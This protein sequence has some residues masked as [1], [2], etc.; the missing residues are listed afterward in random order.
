M[1]VL[2]KNQAMKLMLR[3]ASEPCL[4]WSKRFVQRLRARI[5]FSKKATTDNTPICEF[6]ILPTC[7]EKSCLQPEYLSYPRMLS[8]SWNV[9]SPQSQT[10][11]TRRRLLKPD[12]HLPMALARPLSFT[13]S[14][15]PATSMLNVWRSRRQ[16]P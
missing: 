10:V 14:D 5:P 16:Q 4:P 11:S 13:R 15:L 8:V 2:G 1:E 6:S 12:S 3:K 7:S 9:A